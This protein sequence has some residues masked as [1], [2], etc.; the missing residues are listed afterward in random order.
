MTIEA[1]TDEQRTVYQ[2]YRTAKKHLKQGRDFAD[3]MKIARGYDQ[4]RREAMRRA[5][6]NAPQGAAYR[7][8]FARIDRREKLI[9]RDDTGKEFPT[10][11]DRTYCVKILENYDMPGHDPRRV[12]I[13]AWRDSLP[14]GE[15]AKLNHPK[16][17][18]TSYWESTEPKADREAK[19]KAREMKPPKENPHLA[20]LADAEGER[21]ASRRQ[22]E[23]LRG[24]LGKVLSQW[25]D[26]PPDLRAAIVEALAH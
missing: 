21:D 23:D 17:V 9:D 2:D 25:D 19:R 12:S 11:E 5:G 7:E 13:K 6:T 22:T 14:H 26:I 16:R 24:L 15:R 18:W 4:A 1:I 20:A 10:P 3:W 8:A